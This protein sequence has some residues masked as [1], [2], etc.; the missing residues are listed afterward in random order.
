MVGPEGPLEGGR[1]SRRGTSAQQ[2]EVEHPLVN[3]WFSDLLCRLPCRFSSWS[4]RASCTRGTGEGGCLC[5]D[6]RGDVIL[7]HLLC[8]QG[9]HG[10]RGV[11]R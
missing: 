11:F 8:F 3:T 6:T 5:N 2:V 9:H 10:R 4:W 7:K 1:L